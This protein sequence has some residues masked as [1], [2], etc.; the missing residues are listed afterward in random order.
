MKKISKIMVAFDF[1]QYSK[2]AFAYAVELADS[3]GANLVVVHII[4]ERD[5]KALRTITK[6]DMFSKSVVKYKKETMKLY[7]QNKKEE[8]SGEIDKLIEEKNCSHLSIDKVFRV[9][10]P[11]QELI[12]AA[13]NESADLMVMGS[14]GRSGLA[15]VL[16]GHTAEKMFRRCPVPLLS[17]RLH[18]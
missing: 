5:L 11:F 10:V 12:N 15:E 13:K 16:F 6:E 18:N 14:K 7:V 1:S 8:L 17:I 2:N 3:L 9:G 4:N